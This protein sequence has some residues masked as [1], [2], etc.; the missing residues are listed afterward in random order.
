[1]NASVIREAFA[2][3]IHALSNSVVESGVVSLADG[4]LLM[5][6]PAIVGKNAPTRG[7]LHEIYGPLDEQDIERMQNLIGRELP[8]QLRQLFLECNGF[9][10]FFGS[11]S[12][13]GYVK[14]FSRS[15]ENYSPISLEYG[16]TKELPEEGSGLTESGDQVRFGFYSY[17]DGFTLAI[18]LRGSGEV[19]LTPQHKKGPVFFRWSS[20]AEFLR[21]E[22]SRMVHYYSKNEETISLFSSIPPPHLCNQDRM[23][24]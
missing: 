24:S 2:E 21:F 11:L 15:S 14:S 13:G 3:L 8:I 20:L 9:S 18:N 4:T 23:L 16:N 22:I 17:G 12:I 6:A 7:Y 1:M 10:L 5:K 19:L